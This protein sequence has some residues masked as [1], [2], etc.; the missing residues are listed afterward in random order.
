MM[1]DTCGDDAK[2]DVATRLRLKRVSLIPALKRRAKFKGRYATS[3]SI[4]TLIAL[5]LIDPTSEEASI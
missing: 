3:K 2:T 4:K 1:N 5:L